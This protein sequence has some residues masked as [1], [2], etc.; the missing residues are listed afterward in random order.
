MIYPDIEFSLNTQLERSGHGHG[1]G[2]GE[3]VSLK[4]EYIEREIFHGSQ[5]QRCG[6]I[7]LTE[8]LHQTGY[9]MSLKM[10]NVDPDALI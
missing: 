5:D 1:Q 4:A 8:K 10:K 2:E 9:R 6:R 7:Y 3:R